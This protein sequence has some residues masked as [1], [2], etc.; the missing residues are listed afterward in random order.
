MPSTMGIVVAAALIARTEGRSVT[1]SSVSNRR[2]RSENDIR[3]Q[4]CDL[5]RSPLPPV[6]LESTF[7]WAD[8]PGAQARRVGPASPMLEDRDERSLPFRDIRSD[9]W[10][11]Q[12]VIYGTAPGNSPP[13][14]STTDRR[15]KCGKASTDVP[16]DHSGRLLNCLTQAPS[17]GK[18]RRRHLDALALLMLF[19]SSYWTIAKP[20]GYG[21]SL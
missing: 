21:F 15:F 10:L 5:P 3:L 12:V 20:G 19:T 11:I 2:T 13:T 6:P 1:T 17:I 7:A 4:H 16:D 9:V 8:A 14:L 18:S